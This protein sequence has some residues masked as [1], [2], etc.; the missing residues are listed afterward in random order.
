MNLTR[1]KILQAEDMKPL[2]VSVPEWGGT[3]WI[4]TL[5]GKERLSYEEA[6]DKIKDAGDGMHSTRLMTHYL[7]WVLVDKEG[8]RLFSDKDIDL[9]AD[10]K[11]SV[12]LRLY[13]KASVHNGTSLQDAE[14]LEKN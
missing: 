1:D 9:L 3:L 7:T 10:K 6:V 13:N 11:A 12:L 2:R 5:S 4:R 8:K 14:D